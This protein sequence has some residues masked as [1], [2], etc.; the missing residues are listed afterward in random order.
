MCVAIEIVLQLTSSPLSY[1]EKLALSQQVVDSL[2][3]WKGTLALNGETVAIIG[4]ITG[5]SD[6]RQCRWLCH[7]VNFILS[8]C[9]SAGAVLF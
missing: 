2:T 3:A 8:P 4:D 7:I 5:N 1:G 9:T 6:S